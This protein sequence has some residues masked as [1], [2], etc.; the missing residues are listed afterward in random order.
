MAAM[1]CSRQHDDPEPTSGATTPAVQDWNLFL[2]ESLT[3]CTLCELSSD[4]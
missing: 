1:P 4:E 2:V 3:P